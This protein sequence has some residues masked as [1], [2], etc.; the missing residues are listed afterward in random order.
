MRGGE[1]EIGR[2]EE[3]R[4]LKMYVDLRE[5]KRKEKRESL[6]IWVDLEILLCCI[7]NI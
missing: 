1:S 7:W 3:G 6:L 4:G 5:K 2:K